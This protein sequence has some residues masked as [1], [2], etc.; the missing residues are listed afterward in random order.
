ML[1][2]ASLMEESV[3]HK[4]MHGL[5]TRRYS[6]IVRELEQAYGIE[7]SAVSEHFIQA[8]RQRL[9][10]L[11]QRPL[12][13][14]AIG[15]MLLDG[16]CY[17]DQQLVVALGVT[18]QGHKL[19]LGLEQGATENTTVVKHLLDDIGRR[20]VDFE[21]PRL[22][23]VDGGKALHAAIRKVAGKPSSLTPSRPLSV[24]HTSFVKVSLLL[25]NRTPRPPVMCNWPR[26]TFDPLI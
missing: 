4:I 23:V 1:Q 11:Q 14:H 5:T 9:Q 19:V 22:Y 18:L 7:K 16:T 24:T 13:Q 2:Q 10:Q 8:S 17:E 12:G 3:W 25:S 6:R 15:A 21:M 26:C 20:G